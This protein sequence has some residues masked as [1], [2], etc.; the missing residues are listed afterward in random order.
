MVPR[1]ASKNLVVVLVLQLQPRSLD[2]LDHYFEIVAV[3]LKTVLIKV[4][5]NI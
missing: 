4:I 3:K 1:I 2:H 5:K